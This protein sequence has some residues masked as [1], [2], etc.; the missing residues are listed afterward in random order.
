L[1]RRILDLVLP[2]STVWPIALVVAA[3]ACEAATLH[4]GI[5]DLDEGYFVQQAVRVF[6]GQVP[7][8][9]FESLYSPGLAYVHAGLF[10]ITGSPSLLAPRVLA[11]AARAAIAVLLYV[12]ARPLVRRPIWAAAPALVLLLGI[13]DAPVRWEPHP[14]WL[15]TLFG[16]LA[17]WC[18]SHQPARR[19]LLAGGAAAA[20]AYVF[21][22]NT[23][24]FIL[25]A[26]L[27]WYGRRRAI[28]PLLTFGAV[29]ALW[30]IPLV[31]AV[32][33]QVGRLG[34]LVG[35]VNQASLVS[36]P[37]P[38]LLIPIGC[39]LG[40][41][42][43][44]RRDS[45]P[46]TRWYLL[47]GGALF[48]TEF[49]RMDTLH[50]AWSAPLLLVLGAV[51]LDRVATVP[52]VAGLLAVVVLLAPNWSSR[53]TFLTLPEAPIAGVEAPIGTA[54]DVAGAVAEIE[55][56]TRSGEPI[57]VYPTSPLLYVL[58]DRPN[59][60][61]FDHLNPGAADP[62]QIQEVIGDLGSANVRL[63][64]ISDFWQ[65]AWGA[66]GANAVLED[67]LSRHYTEVGRHGAYRVLL[68]DQ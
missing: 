52:A 66:P 21:K 42:W 10:A 44:A 29:T 14:G 45:H 26:I 36:A 50:L 25:A 34:V 40:G 37:E 18:L 57:F 56:R 28:A 47:A 8:R 59:P 1:T 9:D 63:V 46:T 35:V 13:D 7:Y 27:V 2:A 6:H 22:Q 64:V 24:V 11:L 16:L 43:L 4:R 48:L 67:W 62:A 33:G 58:A 15:S 60:T 19:W 32:D 39:L 12:M 51:A 55:Q 17:A 49:P 53:L 41:V 61:R 54:E 68:A 5:D 31:S 30:L 38:T 65:A 20:L 3:L 23:G